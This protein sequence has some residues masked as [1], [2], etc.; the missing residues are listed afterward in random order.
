MR[1]VISTRGM[2]PVHF[3]DGKKHQM[4]PATAHRVLSHHD[5]LKTS[6]E[7]QEYAARIHRSKDSMND[8]LSGKPEEKKPKISLGGNYKK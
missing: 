3:N 8:A 7:K 6:Q 2:H 1:K 5:N 4:N